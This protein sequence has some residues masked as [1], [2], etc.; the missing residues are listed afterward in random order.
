MGKIIFY[1]FDK[2][3]AGFWVKNE[4][5]KVST[6]P[7]DPSKIDVFEMAMEGLMA[8]RML[9]ND[10]EITKEVM[11]IRSREQLIEM[12]VKNDKE[13]ELSY[14]SLSLYLKNS[15]I[16]IAPMKRLQEY[17]AHGYRDMDDLMISTPIVADAFMAGLISQ[18][19]KC[20]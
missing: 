19:D 14:K 11:S 3:K 5:H 18:I 6:Y 4:F 17:N 20:L 8:S 16:D 7:I 2:L 1:S 12:G 15:T 9:D 10:D 13:M